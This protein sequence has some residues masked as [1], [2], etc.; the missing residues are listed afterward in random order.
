M[1]IKHEGG[2]QKGFNTHPTEQVWEPG[3]EPDQLAPLCRD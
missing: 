1:L 3:L 2:E